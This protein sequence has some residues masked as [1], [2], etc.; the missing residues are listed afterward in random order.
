ML[1]HKHVFLVM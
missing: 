1:H